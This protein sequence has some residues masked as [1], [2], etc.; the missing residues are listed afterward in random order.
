R[1]P[2]LARM[3]RDFLAIPGSSVS[4][5]RCLSIGRDVISLRRASLWAETIRLLMTYRAELLLDKRLAKLTAE[6][7]LKRPLQ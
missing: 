6:N 3:A 7:V 5:E 1:Y 2:R 4:V